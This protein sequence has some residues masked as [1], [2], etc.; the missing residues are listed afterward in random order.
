MRS[1]GLLADDADTSSVVA[2]AL[3]DASS[4][5]LTVEPEGGSPQPTTDP[6]MLLGLT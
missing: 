5:G 3:G 1:A 6:V 2:G 4:V